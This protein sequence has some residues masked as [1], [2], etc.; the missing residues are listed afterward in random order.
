MDIYDFAMQME[1]DGAKFY[2]DLVSQSNDA[3]VKR[4]FTMLADDEVKHYNVV[5]EMAREASPAMVETSILTDAKNIFAEMRDSPFNLEGMQ[6][7]LYRTGQDIE[8]RSQAF[9]EEKAQ[10]VDR[11]AHRTLLLK[12]AEEEHRHFL[13]LDAIIE[14]V[15]RPQTWME[16]A[17]FTHLDEY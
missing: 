2:G 10:Q 16:N 13:L 9:Y 8:R 4:I 15:N 1:Q 12:L 6:V 11:P 5:K 14:F 17:E 3:G 7:D